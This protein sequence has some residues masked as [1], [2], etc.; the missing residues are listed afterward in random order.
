MIGS[1]VDRRTVIHVVPRQHIRLPNDLSGGL[2]A[3]VGFFVGLP[4]SFQWQYRIPRDSTSGSVT[5]AVGFSTTSDVT[6]SD[7]SVP[8]VPPGVDGNQQK[9]VT[10]KG[11]PDKAA[12]TC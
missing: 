3:V 5:G 6:S 8:S 7:P 1:A 4:R 9:A 2:I 11:L 10:I 12:S